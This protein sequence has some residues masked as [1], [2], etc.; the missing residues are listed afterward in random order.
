MCNLRTC[1]LWS[2]SWLLSWYIES[3]RLASVIQCCLQALPPSRYLEMRFKYLPRAR[4]KG[5][6][7]AEDAQL[8][9]PRFADG[10]MKTAD[11]EI[12]LPSM[13]QSSV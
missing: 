11:S 10:D 3:S 1:C 9:T 2:A 6:R 12:G 8:Q 13:G 7:P 4:T 5:R